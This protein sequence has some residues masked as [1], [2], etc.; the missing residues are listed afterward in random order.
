MPGCLHYFVDFQLAQTEQAHI[1]EIQINV[2]RTVIALDNIHF[3]DVQRIQGHQVQR[4]QTFIV[5]DHIFID[6]VRQAFGVAA[7]A[8]L[9][10]RCFPEK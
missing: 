5:G 6:S 9:Q 8:S 3:V 1:L 7:F 10:I 2:D 4:F